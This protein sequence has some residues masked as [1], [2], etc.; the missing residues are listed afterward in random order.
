MRIYDISQ[1]VFNCNVYS[2]DT[3]PE[4]IKE[5]SIDEGS[6]YNLTSFRMC[7]HNGTHVDAPYH[8]ISSGKT[9]DEIELSKFIGPC[10]VYTKDGELNGE[11]ANKVLKLAESIDYEC[12]KRLLFKGDTIITEEAAE[13]FASNGVLLIGNESQSVGPLNAPMKVHLILLN[14]EV[15]LLEGIRLAH[16]PDG[17]YILNAVPINLEGSDG[18]PCRAI[19]MDM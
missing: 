7:T 4:R 17:R 12:A 2:D 9:I 15:V 18:A 6:L 13:V 14:K 1:E 11:D 16:V 5:K 19:L 10:C 3:K 8:F